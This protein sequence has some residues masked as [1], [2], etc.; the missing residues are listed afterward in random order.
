MA[1]E[2]AKRE[3]LRLVARHDGQWHWYQI[4]RA[5]SGQHP[6]C[7]GPFFAEIRELAAEGMIEILLCPELAGGERYWLTEAGR[8]AVMD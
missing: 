7:I 5:L 3:I 8:A 1:R 4:D 6:D 2:V